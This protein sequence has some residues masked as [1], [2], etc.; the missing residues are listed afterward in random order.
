MLSVVG[1]ELLV[2]PSTSSR[3]DGKFVPSR[4]ITARPPGAPML[5]KIDGWIDWNQ[6]SDQIIC[7]IMGLTPAQRLSRLPGQTFKNSKSHSYMPKTPPT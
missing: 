2:R 1:A 3:S 5:Q 7:R 6:T 4:R